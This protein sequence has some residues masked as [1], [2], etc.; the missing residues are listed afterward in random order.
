MGE[1]GSESLSSAFIVT[2]ARSLLVP[3]REVFHE[4]TK[5]FILDLLSELRRGTAIGEAVRRC[6]SRMSREHDPRD[7]TGL[8]LLGSWD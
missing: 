7:A 4:P 3:R 1:D 6:R 5:A 2:G 8:R